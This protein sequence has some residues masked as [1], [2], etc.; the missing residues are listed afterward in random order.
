ML[1]FMFASAAWIALGLAVLLCVASLLAMWFG[2]STDSRHELDKAASNEHE[3][4][5]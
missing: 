1:T 5:D 3:G 4:T 2:P